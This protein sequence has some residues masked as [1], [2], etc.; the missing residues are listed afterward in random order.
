MLLERFA[1]CFTHNFN[2][3]N[4]IHYNT[5]PYFFIEF[6]ILYRIIKKHI[7]DCDVLAFGSRYKWTNEE[8][9]DLD[10]AVVGETKVGY[11][12]IDE[13][14]YDFMES[15]L[16]FR[17]DVLDYH[18]ISESFRRIIDAGN[19]KIYNGKKHELPTR[20]SRV[21]ALSE[22]CSKIG[23]GATPRGG[24]E[25]YKESGIPLIRSQNVLDY[26]FSTD[27]LAYI[28]DAQA[29]QLDNVTVQSGDI[30]INITGILLL[31]FAWRRMNIYPQ[32]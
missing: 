2:L 13:I 27:G 23:S 30:L 17:V 26:S 3:D 9:S 5:K 28:D 8:T 1:T 19:E 15:D 25:S 10:L 21:V 31:V 11:R 29:V 7:P 12:V 20:E 6:F 32:G 22:V 18:S 16:S 4:I 24:K 14:K